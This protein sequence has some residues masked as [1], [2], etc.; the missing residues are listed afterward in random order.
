VRNALAR[1][2][3]LVPRVPDDRTASKRPWVSEGARGRG[4]HDPPVVR[5][6]DSAVAQA[7]VGV[8]PAVRTALTALSPVAAQGSA[9]SPTAG[10]DATSEAAAQARR[11]VGGARAQLRELPNRQ[12]SHVRP[13]LSIPLPAHPRWAPDGPVSGLR[14]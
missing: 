2:A 7:A 11:Y 5:Q 12:A 6:L 1:G 10:V 4:S 14:R 9:A 13:P 3:R 8:A